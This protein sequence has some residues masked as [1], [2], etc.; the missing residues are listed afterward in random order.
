[1][2][3]SMQ[4]PKV[5]PPAPQDMAHPSKC[6]EEKAGVTICEAGGEGDSSFPWQGAGDQTLSLT[7]ARQELY[8]RAYILGPRLTALKE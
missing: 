8:C 6:L 4:E 1:M 5:Q 2:H 3:T 7:R